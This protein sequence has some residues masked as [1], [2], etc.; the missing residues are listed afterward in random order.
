MFRYGDLYPTSPIGRT[1]AVVL[2][3]T[4][5]II[6]ALPVGVIGSSFS[7]A[8]EEMEAQL[9]AERLGNGRE[10]PAGSN[11]VCMPILDCSFL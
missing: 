10:T 4:G 3:F 8:Y 11:Q 5:I 2:M 1:V 9:R 7:R 6:I